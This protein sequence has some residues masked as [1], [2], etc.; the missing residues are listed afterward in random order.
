MKR[1]ILK[2][3]SYNINHT[4]TLYHYVFKGLEQEISSIEPRIKHVQAVLPSEANS[5]MHNQASSLLSLWQRL[6]H[7]SQQCVERLKST[8]SCLTKVSS[9]DGVLSAAEAAL[10]RCDVGH[11][12]V[13]QCLAVDRALNDHLSQLSVLRQQTPLD[14][15]LVQLRDRIYA[16]CQQVGSARELPSMT[17]IS[18]LVES[19]LSK[20]VLLEKE[21]TDR[22]YFDLGFS[23]PKY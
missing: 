16:L 20:H 9:V 10:T 6:W 23:N 17:Q 15:V 8:Q 7:E 1:R 3:C 18:A 13:E 19:L 12:S 2:H 21:L 4:H 14:E 22:Y 11:E 5:S